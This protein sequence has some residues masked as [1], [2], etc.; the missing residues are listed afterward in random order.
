MI[1]PNFSESQ[2][3]QLINTEITM[4]LFS[5]KNQIYNPIIINLIEEFDL[6][7]D[8]AFY[9]PWLLKSPNIKHRGCN[10]FIQYK[11]SKLIERCKGDYKQWGCSYLR[12][13]IPYPTKNKETKE[14]FDDYHQFDCLK[15]LATKGY[16]VY[17]ATNHVVYERDLFEMSKK[18]ELLDKIPF[19]DVSNINGHHKKVSF[20]QNSSYFLL[21]S[22]PKKIDN[23]KW[24]QI[25]GNIKQEQDKGTSLSDDVEF[26]E[27]FILNFEK[28]LH[29]PKN[30]G[31]DKDMEKI[32]FTNIPEFN[33]LIIKAIIVSKYLK[34]YLNIIWYKSW[35][36]GEDTSEDTTKSLG[37]T[38]RSYTNPTMERIKHIIL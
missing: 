6:G 33:K 1:E 24:G 36:E 27:K 5:Y 34:Q 12:F 10:F 26:L 4:R 30:T 32:R 3:Q 18:Q 22:E 14:Y 9:F 29:V 13:Q 21:H 17:Y 15:D 38:S 31:F 23:T 7:W 37:D 8:T 16:Y 28:I 19:L 35:A 11:L 2:L 25:M 20:T